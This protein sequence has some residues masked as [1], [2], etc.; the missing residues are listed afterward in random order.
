MART[1]VGICR[2]LMVLVGTE[3][4]LGC[5]VGWGGQLEEKFFLSGWLSGINLVGI[6]KV[7]LGYVDW[8]EGMI[9]NA[10]FRFAWLG[11]AG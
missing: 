3:N 2:V 4:W 11:W 8:G 10:R 9:G 6:V 7:G 1:K 5:L